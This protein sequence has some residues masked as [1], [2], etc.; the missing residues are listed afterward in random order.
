MIPRDHYDLSRIACLIVSDPCDD[1]AHWFHAKYIATMDAPAMETETKMKI[2]DEEKDAAY[3][4]GWSDSL[5]AHFAP[6]RVPI[7]VRYYY[8][9]GWQKC[10]DYRWRD[11]AGRGVAPDPTYRE[12][13]RC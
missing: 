10:A 13:R 7:N 3:E 9:D 6:S 2:T 12:P 1:C 11:P 8:I 5:T 4:R